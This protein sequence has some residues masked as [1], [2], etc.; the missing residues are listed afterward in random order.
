M[1]EEITKDLYDKRMIRTWY[2]DKPEGWTLV[3][4]LWSP[5]YIQL[6]PLCSYPSI[7]RKVGKAMGMLLS[8]LTP[9][10]TRIIGLAMAGIPIAVATSL[11]TGIPAT[12]TRKM[13]GVSAYGEHHLIEGELVE[14]DTVAIVDD[15]V[16]RFDSKLKAIAEV[17]QEINRLHLRSVHCRYVAVLLDREQGASEIAQ[18][19]DVRL[20]SLIRFKSDA[21]KWLKDKMSPLESRVISEY[22]SDPLRYQESSVQKDLTTEARRKP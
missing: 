19:A 11:E 1:A 20:I 2:K 16:T 15:V 6:R 21:I 17:K 7:L 18:T 13:N 14:N 8:E 5:F 4:G 12:F 22:L 9:R 3:S 10:P